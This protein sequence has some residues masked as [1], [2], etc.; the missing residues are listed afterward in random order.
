MQ[1]DMLLKKCFLLAAMKFNAA[2]YRE[3]QSQWFGKSGFSWEL[4]AYEKQIKDEAGKWTTQ[5]DIHVCVLKEPSKQTA[6][7][8]V[9]IFKASL[10]VY[11]A[12]NPEVQEIW[13]KSDCAGCYKSDRNLIPMWS[14]RNK[15]PG[16][17][18]LGYVFSEPGESNICFVCVFEGG[19]I[20]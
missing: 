7:D 20:L 14:L 9:A 5:T 19:K 6:E 10:S 8:V 13:L 11:K 2:F 12:A 1:L 3:T 16:L 17:K 18:I 15:I 4:I